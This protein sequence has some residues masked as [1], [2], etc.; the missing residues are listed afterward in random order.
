MFEFS[1]ELTKIAKNYNLQERDVIFAYLI[2][3][4][5]DRA[6]AYYCLY[7][8]GKNLNNTTRTTTDATAADYYNNHPAFKIL[9]HKIKS[10]KPLN[11]VGTQQ[12]IR[13]AIIADPEREE[14]KGEAELKTREG[15]IRRFSRELS[16]VHGKD[17]VQGLIQLAKLEGYDKE[18]TRTEE[19]KRRYF[20]PYRSR[21]RGCKLMQIFTELE[22]Q[23]QET[24]EQDNK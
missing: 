20:L 7:N 6:D 15:L 1:L 18:D 22:I 4:G 14:T 12:E 9:V 8:R 2:A 3:Y 23:T 24:E 10:Q 17:S 11:N 16:Q 19:E 13:E 21:C 5:I